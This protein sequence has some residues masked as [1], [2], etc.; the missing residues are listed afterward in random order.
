MGKFTESAVSEEK[1]IESPSRD[2]TGRFPQDRLLR[3]YGFCIH[4]RPES[5]PTLWRYMHDVYTEQEALASCDEA[6]IEYAE[7][8]GYGCD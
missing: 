2:R 7:R 3:D 8:E 5:G 4:S 1:H 6:D